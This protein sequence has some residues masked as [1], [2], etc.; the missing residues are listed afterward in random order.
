MNDLIEA[1]VPWSGRD[2]SNFDLPQ[3]ITRSNQGLYDRRVLP[4]AGSLLREKV[5]NACLRETG[6]EGGST[7]EKLQ[8]LVDKNGKLPDEVVAALVPL[9]RPTAREIEGQGYRE[10]QPRVREPAPVATKK[11]KR[12]VSQGGRGKKRK[13]DTT[14]IAVEDPTEP[15]KKNADE[16][17]DPEL[18]DIYLVGMEETFDGIDLVEDC[19]YDPANPSQFRKGWTTT[20]ERYA[21]EALISI[22]ACPVD[23]NLARTNSQ[24]RIQR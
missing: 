17:Q 16:N 12:E 19:V 2:R 10:Y 20:R 9:A 13:L 14:Y 18:R 15:E 6:E 3:K 23:K 5:H 21:L 22:R 11:R 4:T 24:E 1:F 7:V 8:A